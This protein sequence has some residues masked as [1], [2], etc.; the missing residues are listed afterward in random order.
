MDGEMVELLIQKYRD[1]L[2]WAYLERKAALPENDIFS[3]IR[4]LKQRP[5]N[6]G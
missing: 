5:G 1:E 3:E 6:E 2:D 4:E